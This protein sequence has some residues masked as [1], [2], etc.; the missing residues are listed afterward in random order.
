[1]AR[2]ED[3]IGMTDKV[4]YVLVSRSTFPM[5]LVL[6]YPQ[7]IRLMGQAQVLLS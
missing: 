7:M 4:Q 2:R 6:M 5:N 1:L 3:V